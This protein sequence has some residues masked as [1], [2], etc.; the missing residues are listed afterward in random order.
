MWRGTGSRPV[1]VLYTVRR[2][3]GATTLPNRASP[4]TAVRMTEL[5]GASSSASFAGSCGL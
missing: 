2:Q 4:E 3:Q 1:A 5:L